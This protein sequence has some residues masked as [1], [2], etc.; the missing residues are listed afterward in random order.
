MTNQNLCCFS[1]E[2]AR[3]ISERK[4][5]Y[6]AILSESGKQKVLSVR[7]IANMTPETR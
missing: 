4:I 5:H 2:P 7:F 1:L 6:A 3:D